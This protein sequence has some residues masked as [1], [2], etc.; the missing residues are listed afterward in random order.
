MESNFKLW[1]H[2]RQLATLGAN[3]L[4]VSYTYHDSG[5]RTSK[6]VNGTK[7]QYYL[8]GSTILTQITGDDRFDFFY[9]DNGLLLG[10]SYN[11]EKYYYIRNLQSDIIGILNSS[12]NQVVSYTYDSWG[13]LLS[14]EG[15]AKDTIGVLNP[16][17]Y[18]GYYYD[19]ES[20]FYYL[21][22]RYYDPVVGRFLNADSGI[23]NDI[24]GAN[25]FV[26]C[27]NN[28][29]VRSDD[30]GNGWWILG[31]ILFG[32]AMGFFGNMLSNCMSG[33]PWNEGW[34]GATASGMIMGGCAM[35]GMPVLGSVLGAGTGSFLNES[36]SYIPGVASF[37]GKEPQAIIPQ[38]ILRS[39]AN[40]AI[41]TVQ[42]SM[43]STIT[44]NVATQVIPSPNVLIVP[45]SATS[46]LKGALI[47]DYA[48]NAHSQTIFSTGLDVSI[49]Y[50]LSFEDYILQL[51]QQARQYFIISLYPDAPFFHQEG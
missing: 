50:S 8:N 10:F 29:I 35:A 38:N 40:V 20:G 37:N 42:G 43:L 14:I 4:S 24:L 11:G 44:G 30:T 31:G 49:N 19:T 34:L 47:S 28:P 41:E 15:S 7:T 39:T 5:I 26:Y 16:F 23:N 12:G 2:G 45:S 3:G 13:K 32:A 22:S 48:I 6:T 27:G 46:S 21:N 17:R 33:R 36:S 25:T 51:P 18:R 1:Q 9:D